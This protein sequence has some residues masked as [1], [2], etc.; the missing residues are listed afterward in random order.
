MKISEFGMV[1]GLVSAI[2]VGGT[3]SAYKP[4]P[5]PPPMCEINKDALNAINEQNKQLFASNE[6]LRNAIAKMPDDAKQ[7]VDDHVAV[8]NKIR[9]LADKIT[10]AEDA[11][12]SYENLQKGLADKPCEKPSASD[13]GL[14][15]TQDIIVGSVSPYPYKKKT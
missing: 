12:Q 4:E 15:S 13:S 6:D 9:T 1:A 11:K 3:I 5:L 7:F 10:Q 8:T 2:S 14:P